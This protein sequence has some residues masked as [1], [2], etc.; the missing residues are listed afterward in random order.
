VR[1]NLGLT[2]YDQTVLIEKLARAGFSARRAPANIGH[3]RARMTFLAQP[4]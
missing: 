4:A 3:N 2:R 1:S